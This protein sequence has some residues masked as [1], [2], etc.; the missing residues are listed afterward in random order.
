ML[1]RWPREWG[2]QA[3]SA[4]IVAGLIVAGV[5]TLAAKVWPK[6]SSDGLVGGCAPFNV[7]AQNQFKPFGTLLWSTLHQPPQTLLDLAQTN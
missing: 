1:K 6:G 5:V 7:Y 3:F 4:A 2:W